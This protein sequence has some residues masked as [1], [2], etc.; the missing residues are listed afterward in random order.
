MENSSSAQSKFSENVYTMN[1]VASNVGL[2]FATWRGFP[3]LVKFDDKLYDILETGIIDFW[4]EIYLE[5][6]S[7][8][9]GE[10]DSTAYIGLKQFA[11]GMM[12]LSI[13]YSLAILAFGSE[14][15]L[16]RY[17]DNKLRKAVT[18]L[19]NKK[20]RKKVLKKKIK[21]APRNVRH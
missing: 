20:W 12:I 15:A 21:R 16:K 3:L 19:A 5:Q 13:G 14:L 6:F 10:E 8:S 11:P 17:R 2:S 4:G 18:I 9:S 1:E 7:G